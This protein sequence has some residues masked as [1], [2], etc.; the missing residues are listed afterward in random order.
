MRHERDPDPSREA[1][2]TGPRWR[3]V[4]RWERG[5]WP[6]DADAERGILNFCREKDLFRHFLGGPL[7]R[8]DLTPD[9]LH[10]LLTEARMRAGRRSA[11]PDD[12]LAAPVRPPP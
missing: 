8:F 2:A 12:P 10:A 6:P 1:D 5:E 3:T 7:A 4:Q 9:S 11:T